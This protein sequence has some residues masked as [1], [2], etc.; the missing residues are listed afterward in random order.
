MSNTTVVQAKK[1]TTVRATMPRGLTA[2][3]AAISVLDRLAPMAAARV[4]TRLWC[5]LPTGRGRSRDDRPISGI[6]APV[7]EMSTVSLG[8]GRTV[9]VE[10][11]GEGSPLYLMHGWGGW[12]GQLGGFVEPLVGRGHRV[13]ALDA[14]SHG[15]SGPGHF[16]PRRTNGLEMMESFRAV[17]NV[18]G[19]PAGVIAHSLGCAVAAW[20]IAE[21]MVAP[22][23][24]AFVAPAVGP[25]PHIRR[26][27]RAIGGTVRTELAML[28][29]LEDMLGRP[30]STFD[31]LRLGDDM[32][33]TL[34]IHDRA[35][36]E[37]G[38]AE[39]EQFA[40]RWA[41]A[42]LEATNG[43][44]HQRILRDAAVIERVATFLTSP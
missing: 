36:K 7:S 30:M 32:P 28:R 9:A 10:S 22:R 25:V 15:E 31:T 23:R 37:V 20:A 35:D 8:D 27:V 24:L 12:R 42:R 4:A 11:W 17:A 26:F 3:R 44:G 1:S 39:A 43:L 29:H 40:Q 13:V 21:G 16:G 41:S 5:T 33:E 18:F 19:P 2:T 6:A 34:I 14:L 38:F